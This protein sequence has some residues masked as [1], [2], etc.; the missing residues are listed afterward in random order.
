PIATWTWRGWGETWQT[1]HQMDSGRSY[2]RLSAPQWETLQRL[3]L[4]NRSLRVLKRES[5][6]L[7]QDASVARQLDLRLRDAYEQ[8]GLEEDDDRCLY[9]EQALR[10]HPDIH[11]HPLLRECLARARTGKTSY[12]G[13]CSYL[14]YVSLRYL[15]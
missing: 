5:P 2:S 8:H 4:L 7:R 12:A 6:D 1:Y 15:I 14:L 13:A 3:G 9:A 11:R 10:F